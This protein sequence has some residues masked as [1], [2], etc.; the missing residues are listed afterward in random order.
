MPA[1]Y[2]IDRSRRVVHCRAWGVLT[3][4]DLVDNRVALHADPVFEPNLAVLY[5]FTDVTEVNVTSATLRGLARGSRLAPT[6]RQAL[7]VSSEEA[8]GMARMYSIFGGN[9]SQNRVF[10]DRASAEAWLDSAR[11]PQPADEPESSRS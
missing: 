11:G 7:I 5:D 1:D 10:R 9:E 8:F 3:D 4:Q 6:A 2:Q